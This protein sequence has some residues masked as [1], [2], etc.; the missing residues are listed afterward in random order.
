MWNVILLPR[1]LYPKLHP[2]NLHLLTAAET[3]TWVVGPPAD[4]M[5]LHTGS[6]VLI[7]MSFSKLSCCLIKNH[8]W[9]Y[10]ED[11]ALC[12]AFS[13]KTFK[14]WF[15]W[16]LNKIIHSVSSLLVAYTVWWMSLNSLLWLVSDPLWSLGHKMEC[17]SQNNS[18]GSY[19]VLIKQ[20]VNKQLQN[21]AGKFYMSKSLSLCS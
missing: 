9:E 10:S 8:L 6:R 7:W 12:L 13:A 18:L 17:Q 20:Y 11:M 15:I 3:S 19:V 4:L 5:S 14:E 2:R 16:I 21:S 1:C